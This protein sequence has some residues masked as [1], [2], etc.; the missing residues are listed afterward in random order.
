MRNL[1]RVERL[2]AY[3]GLPASG[4]VDLRDWVDQLSNDDAWRTLGAVAAAGIDDESKATDPRERLRNL[5]SRMEDELASWLRHPVEVIEY[6]LASS[7]VLGQD[8]PDRMWHWTDTHRRIWADRHG[9]PAPTS[10]PPGIRVIPLTATSL[11]N[12]VQDRLGPALP[13]LFKRLEADPARAERVVGRISRVCRELLGRSEDDVLGSAG[14][15]FRSLVAR[16]AT[17]TGSNE[18]WRAEAL[19]CVK[20]LI[21]ALPE[22]LQEQETPRLRQLRDAI[23][24]Y[25]PP[26]LIVA[27]PPGTMSDPVEFAHG[28]FL[29][30]W[31]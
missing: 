15:A 5:L 4:T 31:D 24:T 1:L 16:S 23:A 18:A 17:A 29:N 12:I 6:F 8:E 10:E 22:G 9:G 27:T 19:R 11:V 7:A 28:H 20:A 26:A 13:S 3:A 14:S 30:N 21:A 2:E 25:T